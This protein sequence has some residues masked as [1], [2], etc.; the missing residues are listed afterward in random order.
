M[1]TPTSRCR[2]VRA[3]T[4][5]APAAD[6]KRGARRSPA[7]RWKRENRGR[8][9][10]FHYME[11]RQPRASSPS[12]VPRS[13]FPPSHFLS[14]VLTASSL[15]YPPPP[16]SRPLFPPSLPLSLSLSLCPS[17]VESPLLPTTRGETERERPLLQ[18]RAEIVHLVSPWFR[19]STP[20]SFLRFS[21]PA[22]S[23]RLGS[24][25]HFY[26]PPVFLSLLEISA[27]LSYPPSRSVLRLSDRFSLRWSC[28]PDVRHHRCR[29]PTTD[30]ERP[31]P[32][33]STSSPP[34]A[35]WRAPSRA[36]YQPAAIPTATTENR[37]RTRVVGSP[38]VS[39]PT[40]RYATP[41]RALRIF[42]KSYI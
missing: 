30:F 25:F 12:F 5:A 18:P 31:T 22:R 24:T 26:Q 20:P 19:S 32:T 4:A 7:L 34:L 3:S 36:C 40:R 35:F 41:R 15:S 38:P 6:E 39:H 10:L 27:S 2:D 13:I 8:L 28:R 16:P 1:T 29:Y 14:I 17:H 9:L 37:D 33:A 42:P 21:V 11:G 23:T